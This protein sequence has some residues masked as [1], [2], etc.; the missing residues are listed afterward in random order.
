M[1]FNIKPTND[2]ETILKNKEWFLNQKRENLEIVITR[3]QEDL[4]WTDGLEHI[5]TIYNKG[6]PFTKSSATVINVPNYGVGL[7][8]IFRHII[9]RYDSLAPITFF[10]QGT[11][12]DREDQPLY[13]LEYYFIDIPNSGVKGY[14]TDAY[15]KSNSRYQT[16]LSSPSCISIENRNLGKFRSEVVGIPYKFLQEFWVRGDWFSV[17]AETIRKKPRNYYIYLYNACQFQ[18]GICV[19]ELWFL[20]RS[21][22]CIF[23]RPLQRDFVYPK[24]KLEDVL[25]Q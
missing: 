15:D 25:I 5:C 9:L 1:S 11:I 4:A 22:Y 23:T 20:E 2:L 14:L 6:Q 21:N 8:T 13:P 18:R 10:A 17:T 19:E 7:E 24:L 16:R 3:F 12:A